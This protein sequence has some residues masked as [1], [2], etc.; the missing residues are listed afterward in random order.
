M[1]INIVTR[2]GAAGAAAAI[3]ALALALPANAQRPP[4][5]EPYS[6]PAPSVVPT[7]PT[8]APD[9]GLQV[10][11]VGTGLLIG[12]A[13]GAA[14]VATGRSRRQTHAPGPA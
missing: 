12:A 9:S 13:I 7:Q 8:S 1:T 6:V 5:P 3:A 10:I 14:A 11:Q 4:E 2:T